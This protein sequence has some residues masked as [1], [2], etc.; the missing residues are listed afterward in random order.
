[1]RR[2]RVEVAPDELGAVE[3]LVFV[4]TDVL[5]P[6]AIQVL[7]D[8]VRDRRRVSP[9][10]PVQVTLT[11]VDHPDGAREVELDAE[12]PPD[13]VIAMVRDALR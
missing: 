8:Y 11:R 4:A 2:E 10:R 13:A 1:M 6:V 9:G 7:Y 5:L 3:V 12:G